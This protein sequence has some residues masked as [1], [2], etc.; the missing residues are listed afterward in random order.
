MN[1]KQLNK[2]FTQ[3]MNDRN[4]FA[5]SGFTDSEDDD[6]ETTNKCIL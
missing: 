5:K 1:N 4:K 6:D 2:E 3:M